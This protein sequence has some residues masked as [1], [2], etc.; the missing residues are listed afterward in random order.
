MPPHSLVLSFIGACLLWVDGLAS[1][2]AAHW[3]R[4]RWP[5]AP[6]WRHTLQRRGGAEWSAA[7]WIKNGP[8]QRAGRDFRRGCGTRGDY[9]GGRIRWPMPALAIGI[10]AGAVCYWMVTRVKAIFGMMT[11][12]ML[13]ASTGRAAQLERCSPASSLNS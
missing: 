12:W 4:I 11:R 7:E 5:P 10:I 9:S 13:S 3:R 6:L 1:T 2:P 8:G